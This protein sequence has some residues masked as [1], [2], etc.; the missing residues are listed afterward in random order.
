M[1]RSMIFLAL[2]CL[3][4]PAAAQDEAAAPARA[5]FLKGRWEEAAERFTAEAG[6][7]V[8]AA[9][10]LAQCK[11][12]RGKRADAQAALQAARERFPESASVPAELA[13]LALARGDHETAKSHAAAALAID[14]DCLP[15]RWCEAELLR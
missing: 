15:A 2:L 13:L 1:R 6:R 5:L 10:G 8:A 11:L 12:A 9:L 14:K 3:A 4:L 7:D